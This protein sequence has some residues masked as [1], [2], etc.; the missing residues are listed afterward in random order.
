M[1]LECKFEEFKKRYKQFDEALP[2]MNLDELDNA[3]KCLG[4]SLLNMN[5]DMWRSSAAH[6]WKWATEKYLKREAEL[7]DQE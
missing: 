6:V 2:T 1:S 3:M 5:E 7:L 4:L